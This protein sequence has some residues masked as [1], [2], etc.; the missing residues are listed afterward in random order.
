MIDFHF[1]NTKKIALEE[2][3]KWLKK[4]VKSENKKVQN[5]VFIFCDDNYLL[6]KNITFLKH[7]TLTDVIT[8]DYCNGNQINGDVFISVERVKENCQKFNTTFLNELD[9]VMV[10]GLLHLLGYKDKTKSEAKIMRQ[11]EDFYLEKK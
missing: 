8:F 2:S 10:H 5:L 4:V 7:K 11:K 9:R 6:E 3:K 1:I